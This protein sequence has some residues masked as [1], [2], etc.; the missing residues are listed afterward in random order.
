MMT[1]ALDTLQPTRMPDGEIRQMQ[2]E[3]TPPTIGRTVLFTPQDPN[4]G[5]NGAIE[6]V[7]V[8]GQV[9]HDPGNPRPY[10]NLLTF[11]PFQAPVWEGSVQE[12]EGPRTW[13]WPPRSA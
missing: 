13:R 5:A 6:Y 9:F 8:V 4:S 11:P 3:F 1:M 2:Q 10:V 7:A 12:G